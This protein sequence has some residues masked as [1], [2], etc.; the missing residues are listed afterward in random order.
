MATPNPVNADTTG[1]TDS[2]QNPFKR[3]KPDSSNHQTKHYKKVTQC[4]V[5]NNGTSS[6]PTVARV[7]NTTLANAPRTAFPNP[8]YFV[9]DQGWYNI[10]FTNPLMSMNTIDVDELQLQAKKYRLKSCG[11]TIKR[12]S[13]S[14]MQV[15][16]N[17]STTT[18]TNQFT[19]VPMVMISKDVDHDLCEQ[20]TLASSTGEPQ[21]WLNVYLAPGAHNLQSGVISC[22][23]TTFANGTMPAVKYAL[24]SGAAPVPPTASDFDLM[25]GGEIEIVSAGGTYEYTWH[26]KNPR[27]MSFQTVF[28]VFDQSTNVV[29]QQALPQNLAT[30]LLQN[31]ATEVNMN[32][33]DAPQM[34]LIRV[35]PLF[36][37]AGP[38]NLNMELW[39]EYHFSIE[40]IGG[41]YL[42]GRNTTVA[43]SATVNQGNLLPY[44]NFYRTLD[45]NAF[46][47]PE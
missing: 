26:N 24:A 16:T 13:A 41:R 32:Q 34:H 14:Q 44:P 1:G 22:F 45:T 38:V 31:V 7:T 23:P 21:T 15:G 28:D 43:P 10:P 39:I 12:V 36:N 33:T 18:I 11:F 19:Q 40:V 2:L 3:F 47:D 17:A 27:W 29:T 6:A 20:T 37:A 46:R 9:Y 25:N 5:T 4:Y 30:V 42:T 35:P 8:A